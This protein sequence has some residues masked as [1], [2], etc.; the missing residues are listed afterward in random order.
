MQLL[1]WGRVVSALANHACSP[2]TQNKCRQ[3]RP[4]D[5]FNFAQA[6]LEETAEMVALLDSLDSFPMDRFED[7]GPVCQEVEEQKIIDPDQ[8][9]ALI[10]LLY[11]CKTLLSENDKKIIYPRLL[12]WLE[13]LD[14]DQ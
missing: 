14:P 10:K 3:L 11:L 2:I 8:C 1:G 12:V 13:R 9:L 5:N 7:I 6:L 4:E